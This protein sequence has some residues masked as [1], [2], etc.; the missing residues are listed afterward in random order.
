LKAF[1]N[2]AVDMRL[3]ERLGDPDIWLDE[4]PA[5]IE[6]IRKSRRSRTT[7]PAGEVAKR[8]GLEW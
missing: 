1:I 3:E 2:D 5:V 6:S 8:L 7:I 4:M